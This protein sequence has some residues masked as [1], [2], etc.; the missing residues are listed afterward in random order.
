[1]STRRAAKIEEVSGA[2]KKALG[3]YVGLANTEE[4]RKRMAAALT[5]ILDRLV[6]QVDIQFDIVASAKNKMVIVPKND[7]TAALLESLNSPLGRD[8]RDGQ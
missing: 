5:S 6:P 7:A 2:L 4:T 8:D 3:S 1:V